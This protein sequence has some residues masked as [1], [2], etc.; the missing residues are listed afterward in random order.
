MI[1][2]VDKCAVQVFSVWRRM[3]QTVVQD[4]I[5][6]RRHRE[7]NVYQKLI[8]KTKEYILCQAHFNGNSYHF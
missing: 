1:T 6:I 3:V 8:E 2:V 5:I 7:K 4:G